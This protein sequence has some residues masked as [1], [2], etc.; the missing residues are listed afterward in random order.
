MQRN[1]I[2]YANGCN[3]NYFT[4]ERNPYYVNKEDYR[5]VDPNPEPTFNNVN[6]Y[7]S[8]YVKKALEEAGHTDVLKVP[9]VE[10]GTDATVKGPEIR[11]R[12]GLG[13]QAI[14]ESLAVLERIPKTVD[15]NCSFHVHFSVEGMQV[16]SYR[17]DFHLALY[18]GLLNHL[19]EL[20]EEVKSRI[21]KTNWRERYFNFRAGSDKYLA[22]AWRSYT[23]EFRCFG[24]VSS[25]KDQLKCVIVAAKAFHWACRAYSGRE[26]RFLTSANQLE[27]NSFYS[28]AID[29]VVRGKTPTVFTSVIRQLRDEGNTE[30]MIPKR[31]RKSRMAV[32]TL[33][34]Q[35]GELEWVTASNS[36][37]IALEPMAALQN[38]VTHVRTIEP[39][40]FSVSDV[41]SIDGNSLSQYMYIDRNAFEQHLSSSTQGE[42]QDV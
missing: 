12:G 10:Y 37:S 9:H 19:H 34:V 42:Q 21:S 23:W 17:T 15:S 26:K 13:I 3:F 32:P 16:G 11:T 28:K 31:L 5:I 14:R 39:I 33:N 25:Y 4:N 1:L 29:R 2:D 8:H 27:G 38:S 24:G 22:V 36:W 41:Q 30:D 35:S 40:S 7:Y 6:S 18:E 20:P